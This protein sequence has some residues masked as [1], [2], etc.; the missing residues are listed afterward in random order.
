MREDRYFIHC[1]GST[2]AE[3]IISRTMPLFDHKTAENITSRFGNEIRRSVGIFRR[4]S[5]KPVFFPMGVLPIDARLVNSWAQDILRL[6]KLICGLRHRMSLTV[7]EYCDLFSIPTN[8]RPIACSREL[9]FPSE[10]FRPDCILTTSGPKV[11]EFNI[12][13]GSMVFIAGM[14]PKNFYRSIP[15][16]DSFLKKLSASGLDGSFWAERSFL[17]HLLRLD[18]IGRRICIWDVPGREKEQ[19]KEREI[20]LDY[21]RRTGLEV[22]L[23]EGGDIVDKIS[24][25]MYVFRYFSYNHFL[26]SRKYFDSSYIRVFDDFSE[27]NDISGSSVVFDNKQNLALLWTTKVQHYLDSKELELVKRYIPRTYQSSTQDEVLLHRVRNNRESWIIKGGNGFQGRNTS[28]GQ[29]CSEAEWGSFFCEAQ[30]NGDAVFQE[31]VAPISIPVFLTD[32]TNQYPQAGGHIANFYYVN[33]RFSGLV[34]RLKRDGKGLKIG[35][36]NAGDVVAALPL[37]V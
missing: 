6:K 9:A 19:A 3:A 33:D 35:A 18:S 12:D 10:Y 32:G 14:A 29:D 21:F 30:K 34:F 31:V 25:E 20:E 37:L 4:V 15:G 23:I 5:N 8:L 13:P 1:V 17:S 2:S 22:E 26:L 36:I 27:T 7:D 16:M 24:R 28:A 11:L